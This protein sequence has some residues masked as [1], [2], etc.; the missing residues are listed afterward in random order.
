MNACDKRIPNIYNLPYTN[1]IQFNSGLVAY[2]K[3][4]IVTQMFKLLIDYFNSAK[5]VVA[6]PSH[7]MI[8][9]YLTYELDIQIVTLPSIYHTRIDP[10]YYYTKLW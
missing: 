10:F 8:L 2:R 1:L 6:S 5:T 7:Q 3:S 4:E 9:T